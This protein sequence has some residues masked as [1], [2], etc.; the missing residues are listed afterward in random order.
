MQAAAFMPLLIFNAFVCFFPNQPVARLAPQELHTFC[1]LGLLFMGTVRLLTDPEDAGK[2][3]IA[4]RT[5]AMITGYVGLSMAKEVNVA[6]MAG[7]CL[8]L[9]G[10]SVTRKRP[11]LVVVV[12]SAVAL[13][14]YTVWRIHM[15][16]LSAHY[17][18]MELGIPLLIQNQRWLT[19][20]A[21]QYATSP[22][23][24]V[25]IAVSLIAMGVRMIRLWQH[26]GLSLDVEC[27]VF[28]L[29]MTL[30]LV[31]ILMI[32]WLPVLRYFYPLVPL[33]GWHVS[34]GYL[35]W[36][37]LLGT[38]FIRKRILYASC[39]LLL[40]WF[41]LA[42]YYGYL[43]QFAVQH[44][45]RHIEQRLLC[46]MEQRLKARQP[47][48]VYCDGGD[49]ELELPMAVKVYFEQ[50]LPLYRGETLGLRTVH[51]LQSDVPLVLAS[52][53]VLDSDHW[54][55]LETITQPRDD[56]LLG[57]AEWVSGKAQGRRRPYAVQDN[58]T[59][60]FDYAWYIYESVGE[61]VVR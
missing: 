23:F 4:L 50:Y 22:V 11:Y 44:H 21:F 28:S 35:E 3:V 60:G 10:V 6:L 2:G 46:D 1:M 26:Y 33:L 42:N 41:V 14:L 54:R 9:L 20:D 17:A 34:R 49:P 5:C 52:R 57:V 32:S 40:G 58:G 48:A 43:L 38:H 36:D 47:V 19:Q 8:F 15:A 37:L 39:L 45:A 25:I 13:L 16:S 27:L 61:G 29:G 56:A 24:A 18:Q 7:F 59:H 51:S 12:V 31:A 30:G 55:L 53:R